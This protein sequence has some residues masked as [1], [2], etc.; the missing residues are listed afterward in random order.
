MLSQG[1]LRECVVSRDV[2]EMSRCIS[3]LGMPFYHHGVVVEA[4]ELA[5]EQVGGLG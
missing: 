1:A 5:F 3:E 4:V 2:P